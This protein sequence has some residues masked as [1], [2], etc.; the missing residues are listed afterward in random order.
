MAAPIPYNV[1][2]GTVLPASPA[3]PAARY[4]T[5]RFNQ[6]VRLAVQLS[7][8]NFSSQ[9]SMYLKATWDTKIAASDNT[10][11][12]LS[13]PF[14][15]WKLT[16]SKP[17]QTSPDSNATYA[18]QPVYFGEGTAMASGEFLDVDAAVI[19]AF[20]DVVSAFSMSTQ[21]VIANSLVAYWCNNDGHIFST[22]TWGGLPMLNFAPRSRATEGFNSSDKTGFEFYL[23]PN[24][25]GGLTLPTPTPFTG[26]SGNVDLRTYAW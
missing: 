18:G 10:R 14:A 6:I 13:P 12:I 26:T 7:G 11:I 22:P 24:W 2:L 16:H 17:L 5:Q 1:G 19:D 25:D 3:I 4:R 9:A 21:G 15:G 8:Q 20:F 23:P